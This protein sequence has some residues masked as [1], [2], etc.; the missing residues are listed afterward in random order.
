MKFDLVAASIAIAAII[1]PTANA[2]AAEAENAASPTGNTQAPLGGIALV[3]VP[4]SHHLHTRGLML[5]DSFSNVNTGAYNNGQ[6]TNTGPYGQ[7][8]NSWNNG[9]NSHQDSASTPYG[10]SGNSNFN[11]W[12]NQHWDNRVAPVGYYGY[13]GYG[14]PGYGYPT[15]GHH[16]YGYPQYG[17]YPSYYRYY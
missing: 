10:S 9:F 2:A 15:Y 12:N 11:T 1:A 14:H 8:S 13:G 5:R 17:G 3:A 16:Q 6:I 4:P 7:N